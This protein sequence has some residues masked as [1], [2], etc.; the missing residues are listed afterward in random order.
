V[1]WND[2]NLDGTFAVGERTGSIEYL[3]DNANFT[4]YQQT[5]LEVTKNAAGQATTRISYTFGTDEI[6]QTIRGSRG[7]EKV[8]VKRLKWSSLGQSNQ[9]CVHS[10]FCSGL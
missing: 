3:I 8:D 9:E 5:I 7:E 10:Q 1:D 6:T 2:A 4:G